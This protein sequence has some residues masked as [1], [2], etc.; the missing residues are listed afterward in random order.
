MKINEII[1]EDTEIATGITERLDANGAVKLSDLFIFQDN[2]DLNQRWIKKLAAEMKAGDEIEPVLI[3]R[4]TQKFRKD[5]KAL[6]KKLSAM[7][8]HAGY[9]DTIDDEIFTTPKKWLLLDGNH[10]YLAA[11]T[12]GLVALPAEVEDMSAEDYVDYINEAF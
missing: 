7:P 6:K 1:T 9:A 10:R 12:A 3:L 8:T 2:A 11:L 5:L 4:L